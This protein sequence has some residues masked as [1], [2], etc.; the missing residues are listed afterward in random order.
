M[1]IHRRE[2]RIV[3][4]VYT[5]RCVV[6]R[7]LC[8]KSI[9]LSTTIVSMVNILRLDSTSLEKK[10]I[11]VFKIKTHI[12]LHNIVFFCNLIL[13]LGIFGQNILFF[14]GQSS[15]GTL[16]GRIDLKKLNSCKTLQV[17]IRRDEVNGYLLLN[18]VTKRNTVREEIMSLTT[19]A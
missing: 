4:H 11:F 7:I 8:T 13:L 14:Y 10:T 1:W 9:M 12:L 2:N 16:I 17:W 6:K 19:Y 3:Q 5:R 18:I 15:F